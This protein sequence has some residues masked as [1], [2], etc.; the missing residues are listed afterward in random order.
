MLAALRARRQRNGHHL[1]EDD[2]V[3]LH[4]LQDAAL[5]KQDSGVEQLVALLKKKGAWDESL[6]A[7]AGD[8][9]AGE[10]PEVPFDPQGSL[11]ENRLAVPLVVKFPGG[12]LSGRDVPLPVSAPDVSATILAALGIPVP[13]YFEGVDL[14]AA[15]HGGVSVVT[16]PLLA[17][18][19]GRY[20]TRLGSWLLRGELGKTPSL[21]AVDLDPACVNDVFDERPCTRRARC[22]LRPSAPRAPRSDASERPKEKA[23]RGARPGHDCCPHCLGRLALSLKFL[24]DHPRAPS[25]DSTRIGNREL[26]PPL[27]RYER[28][29]TQLFAVVGLGHE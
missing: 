17:T 4:A 3:H 21:C 28:A 14:Y 1:Q 27:R 5:A 15:A 23:A 18:G 20:S 2:W 25:A 9:S 6:I 19:A 13:D 16:P 7:F 11:D 22:G 26:E 24:V 10:P 8:V 29:S 12:D